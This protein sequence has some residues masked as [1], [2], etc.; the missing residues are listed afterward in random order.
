MSIT[1]EVLEA[2]VLKL[3]PAQRSR[4]LDRLIASLDT[5]TAI[6]EAWM[7]E[8]RRCDDEIEAGVVESLPL[9]EVLAQLRSGLR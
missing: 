7:R 3:P 9:E 2:E 6:E 8:A 4:L 1:L 5:D